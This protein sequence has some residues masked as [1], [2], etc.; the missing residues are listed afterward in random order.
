MGEE[1][2]YFLHRI[3][4]GFPIPHVI[5]DNDRYFERSGMYTFRERT[6]VNLPW[7]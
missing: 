6:D 7:E 3:K 1:G 4:D 5:I 2:T